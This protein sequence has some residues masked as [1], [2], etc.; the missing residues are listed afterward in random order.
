MY[1]DVTLSAGNV[2]LRKCTKKERVVSS[3]FF[4]VSKIFKETLLNLSAAQRGLLP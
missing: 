1:V 3:L 2:T 4:V